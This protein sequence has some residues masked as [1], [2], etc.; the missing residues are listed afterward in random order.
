MND[1]AE[2]SYDEVPY[3]DNVF[4]HTQ[5][6]RMAAVAA[7]FG[8]AAAPPQRCRVLELGCGTGANLLPMALLAPESRFLGIDLSQRQIAHGNAAVA[9]LGLTNLELKPLSILDVGPDFGVFDY[10]ICHGVFSW[11]PTAVQ[12]K[13]FDVCRDHLAPNGVAYISYNTYPGWHVRGMIREMMGFHVRRFSDPRRRVAE[14]R[15]M[16]QFL[17]D[18]VG[19]PDTIWG[20]L[21]QTE[22]NLLE[23]ASDTYI[24]HEHLED[25]NQPLY[26]YQFMERAQARGL[27]YLAE[28]RPVP[29]TQN[30][31]REVVQRLEAMAPDLIQG[32]QYLD[33]VRNRTFR[34]TLLCPASASLTRPPNPRAVEQLWLAGRIG[35]ESSNADLVSERSEPFLAAD[36]TRLSTNNPWLKVALKLVGDAWPSVMSFTD[37]MRIARE[38]IG[39]DEGAETLPN[40]L[41]QCYLADLIQLHAQPSFAAVEPGERPTATRLARLQAAGKGAI[42]NLQ[43]RNVELD[44]PL[45]LLLGLLD[46]S[47]DRDA[48][49]RELSEALASNQPGTAAEQPIPRQGLDA[50]LNGL[51]RAGLLVEASRVGSGI[52]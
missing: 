44:R 29:L 22:A 52:G 24:Y 21:L 38:R 25:V 13:I 35:P 50:A 8:V 51:A 2:T 3:G 14:A 6:E 30:L 5:P 19:A 27:Q 17:I 34:R 26:F 7:L 31:S 33:F 32:E 12:D 36:G 45:R 40:A 1:A 39:S 49:W 18:A 10:I 23:E 46:G 28:A 4:S 15:W 48:I 9:T 47:R 11:V 42:A 43:H 20:G 37:L 41:L 16:L